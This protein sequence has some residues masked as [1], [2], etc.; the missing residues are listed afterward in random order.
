MRRLLDFLYERR[1]IGLFLILEIACI[2]LL[3]GYNRRYNASFLNSSNNLAASVTQNSND[4]SN[5]FELAEINQ[6]LIKEN[7]SLRQQVSLLSQDSFARKDTLK[8]RY[9]ITISEVISN[10]FNRDINFITISGGWKNNIK[11]G[12]GVI[13]AEGV[14]GQVKAVSENFSTVYSLLHP[15]LLISSHIKRTNTAATVQW[16]QESYDRANL[17]YIPRHISIRKG[18]TVVT[19]GFNAVFPKDILVGIIDE[20]SVSEEMTFYEAKIKLTTD[21]TSLNNVYV[22]R[23]LLEQEKDSLQQL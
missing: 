9:L 18:D 8:S 15:N 6:K 4:I 12:M 11:P 19:S 17:K 20:F 3:I 14:V 21:F 23:D 13:S 5:Y 1:E 22:I 7:E 10:T 16:D 2:W